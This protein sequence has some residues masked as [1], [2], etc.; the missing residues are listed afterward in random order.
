MSRLGLGLLFVCMS[1][2]DMISK[3]VCVC[4]CVCVCAC[5]RV[6]ISYSVYHWFVTHQA[7]IL[8]YDKV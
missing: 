6:I 8:S 5:V 2:I 1:P 3:C 4:V 7:P